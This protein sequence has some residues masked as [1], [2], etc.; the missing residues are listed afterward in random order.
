MKK[1]RR[2]ASFLQQA[3]AESTLELC[4]LEKSM[5]DDGARKIDLPSI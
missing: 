5:K 2:N 3:I 1:L 4:L